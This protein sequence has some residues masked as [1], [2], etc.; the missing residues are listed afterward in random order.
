MAAA[1][2]GGGDGEGDEGAGGEA[3]AEAIEPDG[4]AGEVRHLSNRA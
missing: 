1:E 2:E 3:G 4:N